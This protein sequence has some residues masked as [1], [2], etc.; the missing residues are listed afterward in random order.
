MREIP[1]QGGGREDQSAQRLF[2]EDS[3]GGELEGQSAAFVEH[4]NHRRYHEKLDNVAPADA[5]FGGA[6]AIIEQRERNKRKTIEQ[7]RLLHRKPA[8]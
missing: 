5:Y 2:E 3:V 4:Y 6:A 8:A 7:R 1:L